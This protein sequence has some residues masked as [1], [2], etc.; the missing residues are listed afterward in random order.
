MQV[1]NIMDIIKKRRCNFIELILFL[2]LC[3]YFGKI[4]LAIGKI[5]V[6]PNN[7]YINKKISVK[8][9]TSGIHLK[10][11]K[12]KTNH[13]HLLLDASGSSDLSIWSNSFNFAKSGNSVVDP[14]TGMLLVSIKMGLLLSNFGHGPDID[15]E[16]NYNSGVEGDPDHLGRGWAWNLTHYNPATH[17]LNT[18]GGK[19]FF[20]EQ[21]SDG[22]WHPLYHKLKDVLITKDK[23]GQMVI[24]SANGLQDTLDH[25]GYEVRMQQQNGEGV[26]FDY[27]PGTHILNK[28]TDDN[29]HAI[30]L[31]RKDNYLAVTSYDVKGQPVNM[32]ISLENNEVRNIWFPGSS[33]QQSA[34][35]DKVVHLSYETHNGHDL[36]TGIHYFTGMEKQFTYDCNHAMKLPGII[37]NLN[38]LQPFA[39]KCVVSQLRMI[40]GTNQLPMDIDY[41]YTSTN[42]NNHDYLGFN[43]G[44]TEIPGLNRDI[45]FEAPSDYTYQTKED[46]GQIQTIRTYNKYHLLIDTKIVSDKTN[47]PLDETEIYF[48]RTD[49]R[50]GCANTSF[51]QLPDSYSLPLKV[52]TK[53][54]GDDLS[55][56]MKT[57][58]N[59]SYDDDGRLISQTDSYGRKTITIYC[60]Q[61]GDNLCPAAPADW[62]VASLAEKTTVF[63]V[64]VKNST[65]P[66]IITTMHY[67]KEDNRSESGYTL[68]LYKK[69]VQSGNEKRTET[70]YYYQDKKNL[71]TYG[72]LK[73]KQLTGSDL[74]KES[75]KQITQHYQYTLNKNGT[76]TISNY[77][78]T[79]NNQ[80]V[81]SSITEKSLFI[82]KILR[83]VSADKKNIQ[84]F[85]YD[86]LDRLKAHTDAT[87][88]PFTATTRNQY[89]LSA[90]ENS[91]IVTLPGGMQKKIVFDG[92]G[93]KLA[94]YLEKTDLQGNLQ[95]GLWQQQTQIS[96][97]T[98]GKVATSTSYKQ[99]K[100]VIVA[101]TTR[102]DY[103]VMGRL[104]RKYLPDGE[105]EVTAYDNAQ[106]C[107]VHYTEDAQNDRTAVTIGLSSIT[108]KPVEQIV[109]PATTGIL[110]SVRTLCTA[111]DKQPGARVSRMTYDGFD[112]LVSAE[113]PMGRVVQK[114][115]DALGHVT[116]IIDP[117]GDKIHNVYDLTGHVIQHW[118][119]PVQGGQYLLTS[120]GFNA[121]GQKLWSA[122]EDGKKTIYH[123]NIN[124]QLSTIDKDNGH[125]I[126]LSYNNIGQAVTDSL[127]GKVFLQISYDHVNYK[128]LTVTDNTG[129]TTYHY[130]ND[131][132]LE[133]TIHQ[134]INGYASSAETL[135]YNSY[136][137]LVSRTDS[138]H[139]KIIYTS[140]RL[141]RPA[142]KTYQENAGNTTLLEQLVYDHFSR[143]VKK[144]Y[145]SGMIRIFTY[146]PWGQVETIKDSINGKP[147]H[148]ESFVYD[149]N[150]NIIRLQRSDDQNHEA[151]M[152]YHYDRMDNLVS[153]NCDGDNTLCPHDTAFS[154]SNLKAAPVI[155]Q[156]DYTFTRLNRIAGVTEKLIDTSSD[157][158][159][160]LSKTMSYTYADTKAPLR[161]TAISTQWNNQQSDMHAFVYDTNGN[162]I[163][164]GQGNKISYNSF[165]QITQVVNT[166][167]VVSRYDYN[168][169]GKEVKIITKNGIRQMIYQGGTLDGELV[170]DTANNIHRISYPSAETKTIDN[171]ITEWNESSYKGDVIGIIKQDKASKQWTIQQ[172]NVYSPYGMVWSYGKQETTVPAFQQILKGF[173]GEITDAAT[174]W[175]FLGDGHRTY[176]PSQRYFVSEDPAGDGYAFGSNNP[177]MNSDPSGNI[178]HWIGK[179][180]RIVSAVITLG[181]NNAH[182]H[183]LRGIG[184][185]LIWAAM[186]LPFGPTLAI[187]LAFAAPATLAFA[188]ALEPANKGLQQASMITGR[189][190]AGALFIAGVVAIGAGIGSAISGLLAGMGEGAFEG[191]GETLEESEA[192]IGGETCLNQTHV[193]NTLIPDANPD[194]EDSSLTEASSSTES[195]LSL[196]SIDSN[197]NFAPNGSV[198]SSIS[199][200]DGSYAES[201]A[202]SNFGSIPEDLQSSFEDNNSGSDSEYSASASSES[203]I[204]MLDEHDSSSVESINSGNS[205]QAFNH[206]LQTGG[207]DLRTNGNLYYEYQPARPPESN[208][209]K[210]VKLLNNM[211]HMQFWVLGQQ[212]VL[213]LGSKDVQT[214]KYSNIFMP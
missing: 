189:I 142:E 65:L 181:M 180:F 173:D 147:L 212:G 106:R 201:D 186:G 97:N 26:N 72:L 58:V 184:R 44:L 196:M 53:S 105:I 47:K 134:G 101:L 138:K 2:F 190:Y 43:A 148:T 140:D 171:T 16:M 118:V 169:Q 68:L 199:E 149:A 37:S 193:V 41:S 5:R 174:G 112:R 129:V 67:Q 116:T 177:I 74:P 163:I 84:T 111:G 28:I 49:K 209:I 194:E 143:V 168:G 95:P 146:N 213:H 22:S 205:E 200:S 90:N 191:I 57:V 127:D 192:D 29:G 35:N 109:L 154:G 150:G 170:T 78:D 42:S 11:K 38:S 98:E 203:S 89:Q 121:A 30:S 133:S 82:P 7:T 179:I 63:P 126:A 34:Y 132:L 79:T 161:L 4:N 185:S 176:N 207:Y 33:T 18:A 75:V 15:L 80:S 76:E 102:F 110:P 13:H 206:N 62:P 162:M 167:G 54:W 120:A 19:S 159:H 125:H 188:S 158:R 46:N 73:K 32:H 77:I 40:P 66:P 114:Q 6:Y 81:S 175:Q 155:I 24:R 141:L 55:A 139:N 86:K 12:N 14:R 100:G 20:L 70:R 197:T 123:Y 214:R 145:G 1:M 210:N 96:Y 182:S 208:F 36:L 107:V 166:A 51:E 183:L 64:P 165:N 52:V 160:S 50:D 144:V 198:D 128:P 152:H 178:P 88:T 8:K 104:I 156:Q 157:Q 153:M 151:I 211:N 71:L 69:I 92:A 187:G 3:L 60:P 93:R 48:C 91:I 39:S 137:Q 136:H 21:Q 122:G 59:R 103:D 87:G 85:K 25:D 99:S 10:N 9:T 45:L 131:G 195:Y 117:A 172:H 124:G 27:M 202:G 83:V 113:D 164:D 119:M 94:T 115:Y 17:Q 31:T 56:P 135:T 130:Q 61:S 108:G 204:E 23:K